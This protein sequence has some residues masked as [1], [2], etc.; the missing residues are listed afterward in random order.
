MTNHTNWELPPKTRGDFEVAIVCALPREA[1]AILAIWDD[2]YQDHGLEYGKAAGDQNRY[3]T[4]RIGKHAVVVLCL[5]SIG[6]VSSAKATAHLKM[7]YP[8]I[9]LALLVGICGGCPQNSKGEDVLLGD[10]IISTEIHQY[11][12]KKQHQNEDEVIDTCKY[13]KHDPAIRA[14]IERLAAR[15]GVQFTKDIAGHMRDLRTKSGAPYQHPGPE[16]D[17]LFQSGYL[18]KHRQRRCATCDE[19]EMLACTEARTKSCADLGCDPDQQVRRARS[20]RI[21]RAVK[22]G[23]GDQLLGPQVHFG[24][25]GCGNT[26]I[27]SAQHRNEIIKQQPSIIAFEME[28]AGMFG[29]LAGVVIK[30]VS[31]YADSHKNK[32]WQDY[33]TGVAAC[34]A[35]AL[36]ESYTPT[37]RNTMDRGDHGKFWGIFMID[38]SST[39]AANRDFGTIAQWAGLRATGENGKRFLATSPDGWL[40]LVDNADRELDDDE[41]F[42]RTDR[43]CIIITSRNTS[44]QYSQINLDMHPMTI[45]DGM[46]LFLQE[47]KHNPQ[48]EKNRLLAKPLVEELGCLPLAIKHAAVPVSNKRKSLGEVFEYYNENMERLLKDSKDRGDDTYQYRTLYAS[49][50]M[51]LQTMASHR[52]ANNLNRAVEILQLCAFLHFRDVPEELFSAAPSWGKKGIFN[53]IQSSISRIFWPNPRPNQM[54]G[55][56]CKDQEFTMNQVSISKGLSSIDSL[57]PSSKDPQNLYHSD[58][59]R[60]ALSLLDYSGLGYFDVESHVFSMHPLVHGWNRSRLSGQDCQQARWSV[61]VALARI[62]SRHGPSRQSELQRS[63]LSHVDF[64]LKSGNTNL[65]SCQ[66]LTVDQAEV[67]ERFALVYEDSGNY[68]AARAL[69]QESVDA[70]TTLLG[71]K[72]LNTLNSLH[73][74]ST[75]LEKQ[76]DYADSAEYS[77]EAWEGF[78]ALL[79]GESEEAI[80]SLSNYAWSLHG[81]GRFLEAENINR[82]CLEMRQRLAINTAATVKIKNNLAMAILRQGKFDEAIDL[83][84]QANE[85]HKTNSSDH[86]TAVRSLHNLALAYRKAGEIKLAAEKG[87]EVLKLRKDLLGDNHPD[88]LASKTELALAELKLGN[89]EEAKK[90]SLDASIGLNRF[91]GASSLSTLDSLSSL[92]AVERSLGDYKVAEDLY[93]RVLDGYQQH[94]PLSHVDVLTTMTNLASVLN[95]SQRYEEAVY[96]YQRALDGFKAQQGVDHPNVIQCQISLAS[97]LAKLDSHEGPRQANEIHREIESQ[98]QNSYPGHHYLKSQ[99]LFNYGVFLRNQGDLSKARQKILEAMDGYKVKLGTQSEAVMNSLACHAYILDLEQKHEEAWKEYVK[100]LDGYKELGGP[101]SIHYKACVKRFADMRTKMATLDIPEPELA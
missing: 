42:P 59:D 32:I 54:L 79:G 9:R 67:A 100:A 18:H 69:L 57:P 7:S 88:T 28:S 50:E 68:R 19:S 10:V 1:E 61:G 23:E 41:L 17:V 40:L 75:V 91:M 46:T 58:E 27:K 95:Y 49:I 94:F 44:L 4:G 25:I 35:K 98:I 90:L 74:F 73:R 13:R 76:G 93:R 12:F 52:D 15:D 21:Y 92:A 101:M 38:A 3:T 31:D 77:K 14:M 60:A 5:D 56:P 48:S 89:R 34:A 39:E 65:P 72:N 20:E 26:V 33:G 86:N 80:E 24:V 43:G 53:T 87:H 97:V 66:A 8:R 81:L 6:N 84:S 55:M 22:A 70:K 96:I 99:W 78:Q 51:S 63:L 62:I 29:S 83:L 45:E 64:Y 30:S 16:K 37:D 36:L 2:S 85:W 71:R 47:S 82:R 11:D